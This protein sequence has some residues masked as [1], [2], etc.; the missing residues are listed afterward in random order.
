MISRGEQRLQRLAIIKELNDENTTSTLERAI[1]NNR[2]GGVDQGAIQ[3]AEAR[4]AA[5]KALEALLEQAVNPKVSIQRNA[6][7][8]LPAAIEKATAEGMD[9]TYIDGATRTMNDTK[10]KLQKATTAALNTLKRL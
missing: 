10:D 4:L 3:Q 5:F 1:E 9:K 2:Q 7:R 8:L 6:I